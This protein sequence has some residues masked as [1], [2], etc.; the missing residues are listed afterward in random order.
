M[1]CA[2]FTPDTAGK[3]ET[4]ESLIRYA[5]DAFEK[6]GITF[7]PARMSK[8]IRR[9]HRLDGHAHVKRLI[10]SFVGRDLYART[11]VGF[12]IYTQT[13]I[14]DPTGAQAAH[15]VDQSRASR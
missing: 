5:A 15:N 3:Y 2:T 10:D 1:S 11:F 12:E 8:L 13:G 14:K 6:T 9:E 4:V 7:S